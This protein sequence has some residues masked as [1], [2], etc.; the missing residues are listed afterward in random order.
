MA[1][2]VITDA[3]T[4][5]RRTTLSNGLRIVTESIPS[6]RSIS[7]GAWIFTGSRDEPAD[8]AGISHFIEHMVCKATAR[9]RMYHIAQRLESVGGYLNAFTTKRPAGYCAWA[10]A[11]R[12][13]RPVARALDLV[14][15]PDSPGKQLEKEKDVVLEE[16]K[17]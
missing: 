16:M 10:L 13:M 9:P 17:M 15:E 8:E 7:V 6:V 14:P 12:L 1:D 3:K 4:V 2:L 5:F 11:E